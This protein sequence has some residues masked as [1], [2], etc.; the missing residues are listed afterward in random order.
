MSL[1]LDSPSKQ[2]LED[3]GTWLVVFR[4]SGNACYSLQITYRL[5]SHP[6]DNSKTVK[7]SRRDIESGIDL[8][9][10]IGLTKK[11]LVDEYTTLCARHQSH[12]SR[13]D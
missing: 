1:K 3:T 5:N 7:L 9:Q 2:T 10:V 11:E 4:P 13:E 6:D 12:Y 8:K